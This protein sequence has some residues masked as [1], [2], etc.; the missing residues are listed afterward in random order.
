MRR[1]DSSVERTHTEDKL[2]DYWIA[3]ESLFLPKKNPELAYRAALR[4]A[5]FLGEAPLE[6]TSLF[7]DMKTSY[8]TRSEIVHGDQPENTADVSKRTGDVLRR[9]LLKLLEMSEPFEPENTEKDILARDWM[10]TT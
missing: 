10:A 8:G 2:V 3:F 9:A 4:I 1:W 7:K 6:R 5:W